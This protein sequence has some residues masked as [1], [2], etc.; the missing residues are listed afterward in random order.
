MDDRSR[1]LA[2]QSLS[3]KCCRTRTGNNWSF[4]SEKQKQNWK[5]EK[6]CEKFD[7]LTHVD[8]SEV[9]F[10]RGEVTSYV[11][12]QLAYI[13]AHFHF[14]NTFKHKQLKIE[15]FSVKLGEFPFVALVEEFELC[16]DKNRYR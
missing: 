15:T 14:N 16:L 13:C 4:I 5:M 1:V 9:V 3:S 12:L 7:F 10:I 8:Q 11:P 6:H 2:A